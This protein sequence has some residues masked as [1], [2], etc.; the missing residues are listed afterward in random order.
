MGVLYPEFWMDGS[1]IMTRKIQIKQVKLDILAFMKPFIM[2]VWILI[3]FTI[4]LSAL[5]YYCIDF[6]TCKDNNEK[7]E[8]SIGESI[9]YAFQAFTSYSNLDPISSL[10]QLLLISLLFLV[11]IIVT[12]YTANL[13]VFLV[14]ENYIVTI[15]DLEDVVNNNFPVYLWRG[16]FCYIL[17]KLRYTKLFSINRWRA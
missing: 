15:N 17:P 5:V 4:M 6:M 10:N 2:S 1:L 16:K 13:T 9:L 12:A 7:M 8:T 14:N 3:L 11:L